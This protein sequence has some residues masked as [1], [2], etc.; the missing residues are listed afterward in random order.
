MLKLVKGDIEFE[1]FEVP[2][3]EF[4]V[5]HEVPYEMPHIK[6][7]K[8][9]PSP[10]M[11]RTNTYVYKSIVIGGKYYAFKLIGENIKN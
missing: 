5:T 8:M 10:N 2:N 3:S 9:Y 7:T 1:L 4:A 6:A 11:I